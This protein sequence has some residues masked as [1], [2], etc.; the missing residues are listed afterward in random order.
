[1]NQF[2]IRIL[3]ASALFITIIAYVEAQIPDAAGAGDAVSGASSTASNY[4]NQAQNIWSK[5][6]PNA[7]QVKKCKD[8]FCQCCLGKLISNMMLPLSLMTGG[9]IKPCC[10]PIPAQDKNKSS[11][12]AMGAC[13]KISMDNEDAFKRRDAVRCL[14]R[15]DC[16]WWP[17]TELALIN[18]LRTDKNECVRFEAAK[19]IGMG[20]CCTKK[21]IEALTICINGSTKDGNPAENSE[22]VRMEALA[23]L[24]HC[25]SCYKEKSE[26]IRPE[27]PGN[28][29]PKPKEIS[30]NKLS[31]EEIHLSAYYGE[32]DKVPSSKILGNAI[33]TLEMNKN[34]MVRNAK[35]SQKGLIDIFL[36]AQKKSN[37]QNELGWNQKPMSKSTPNE[38]P[39]VPENLPFSLLNK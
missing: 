1:M 29:I 38:P 10:P 21:M 20:C 12:T 11:A 8:K 19:V 36:K 27:F 32:I 5:L 22:K 13:A 4:A 39:S 26:P 7:E 25:I 6:L 23:A 17:E 14:A 9:C 34:V 28:Q 15:V 33:Q 24:Q 16:N 31:Q 37:N 18:A 2:A 35:S 3:L 30:S